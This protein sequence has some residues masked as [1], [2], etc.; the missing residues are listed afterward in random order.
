MD[1]RTPGGGVELRSSGGLVKRA[2]DALS[3]RPLPT[4]LVAELVLGIRGG[5]RAAAAAVFALLGTDTRFTVDRY[6]VW[7]LAPKAPPPRVATPLHQEEWVVVDVETTGGS[8][9]HGHRVTEV[10]AVW[11]SGGRITES[12]AT[13][14]NPERRIPPMITALTGITDSMVAN[15]PPFRAIA[16]R[17]AE[18]LQGRVFV[19]H[20]CA[21][22]W[23]FVG[24]EIGR[25]L[26]YELS[27]R[28][29]CTVRLARKLLPHLP[30]RSLGSLADYFGLRIESHH[31]AL[32][33]AVA[34]AQL[35]IRFFDLLGEKE[36]DDWEA[37][38]GLLR[39]RAPRRKRTA[40]PRSMDSA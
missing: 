20:N 35:L 33:D 1:D 9:E 7:S 5:E 19:A 36:I 14:I 27:G 3:A 15:A 26:G 30:S 39:R 40:T 17:L 21:F 24:H 31:R 37:V 6:G 2:L 16:P 4:V 22:D 18:T 28:Q 32:D 38:Q 11:V 23:R 25:A 12:Y 13:L 10:A 8:P 29:L 34:T